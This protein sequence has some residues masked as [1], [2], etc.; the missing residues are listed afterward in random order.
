MEWGCFFEKWLY[1]RI[2]DLFGRPISGI[3]GAY[4]DVILRTGTKKSL[5][6]RLKL[7]T[8]TRRVSFFFLCF[9]YFI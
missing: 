6:E 7:T 3:P 5:S 9:N 2:N 4:I 8:E 1:G